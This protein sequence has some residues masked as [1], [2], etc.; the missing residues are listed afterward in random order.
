MHLFVGAGH[1][2]AANAVLDGLAASRHASGLP[3]VALQFGPFAETGMAVSHAQQLSALGL[4]GLKPEQVQM[5]P[6]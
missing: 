6:T 2:A 1:Y 3:S 4:H 5:L